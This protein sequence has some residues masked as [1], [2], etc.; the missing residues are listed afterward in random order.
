[1]DDIQKQPAL[2][3]GPLAQAYARLL[4]VYAPTRR[5]KEVRLAIESVLRSAGTAS[6]HQG[7]AIIGPSGSGKTTAVAHAENWLRTQM[8][9][10]PYAPSPLPTVLMTTR[11][12]GKSLSN[13]FL[14]AGGDPVAA[15]R[16]QNDAEMLLKAAAPTMGVV[17]FAID[18][19][20]H[21]F[22]SKSERGA[23]EM[24][25][26]VKT[27]VNSLAKPVIVMGIDGLEDFIDADR[28]LSQRFESKVYLDDP[29]ISTD[30]E[31]EDMRLVLHMLKAVLPC[32]PSCDLDNGDML[33]R[34]LVAAQLRFGSV[35]HRVRKACQFGAMQSQPAVTLENFSAAYREAAPR[36]KRSDEHNPFKQDITTVRAQLSRL[37]IELNRSRPAR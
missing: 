2:P 13:S 24:A 20:H 3:P 8:S 7:L 14:K 9:L 5:H 11:S 12:S 4:T 35:I 34:L 28:E 25:M 33:I 29:G 37:S 26:S 23:R 31:V 19:F 21:C 6:G 15:I 1:M 30:A 16:S 27:I 18:E 17:A 32:E 36:N 22:A 10:D